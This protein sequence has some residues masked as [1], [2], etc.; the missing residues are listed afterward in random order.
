MKLKQAVKAARTKGYNWVAVDGNSI[1]MYK[2]KP[3]YSYYY[4]EWQS[5]DTSFI[6]GYYLDEYTGRKFNYDTRREV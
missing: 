2:N 1:Y 4:C 3:T 5:D 6:D